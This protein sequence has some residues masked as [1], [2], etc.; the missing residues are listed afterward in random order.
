[1][2]GVLISAAFVAAKLHEQV[3]QKAAVS[4]HRNA[5][6]GALKGQRKEKVNTQ[7][8]RTET[9]SGIFSR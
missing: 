7:K 8:L 3:L 1:L 4:H 6:F 2:D 5:L 9:S